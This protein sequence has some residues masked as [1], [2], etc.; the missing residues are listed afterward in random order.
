MKVSVS[1]PDEVVAFL[2]DYARRA[3]SSRSAA[4]NA[5]IRFLRER[6]LAGAYAEAWDEWGSDADNAEWDTAAG[7]GLGR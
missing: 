5:A 3:G 4:V 7:D 2:D 1:L 6:D